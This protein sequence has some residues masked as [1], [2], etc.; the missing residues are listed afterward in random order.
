MSLKKGPI[1]YKTR[2]KKTA[3]W[4]NHVFTNISLELLDKRP[5]VGKLI[6]HRLPITLQLLPTPFVPRAHFRVAGKLLKPAHV[7]KGHARHQRQIR[8]GQSIAGRVLAP[9]EIF[10]E[11]SERLAKFLP[12]G[13]GPDRSGPPDGRE[14]VVRPA[15]QHAQIEV[16]PVLDKGTGF[17]GSRV[18]RVVIGTGVGVHQVGQDGA[19]FA[20]GKVTVHQGGHLV[21]RIELECEGF[22]EDGSCYA[23][24]AYLDE[25]FPRGTLNGVVDHFEVEG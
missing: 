6:R 16:E 15:V 17:W 14:V 19:G 20:D 5:R 23:R 4:F 24:L 1:Q 11:K 7:H 25:G 3:H 18:E 12:V 21:L 9:T 2:H 22:G 13:V 10:L 8:N